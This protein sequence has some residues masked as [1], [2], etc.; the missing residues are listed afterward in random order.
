[1]NP[2]RGTCR[3][4]VPGTP[5]PRLFPSSPP[6]GVC[7][8]PPTFTRAFSRTRSRALPIVGVARISSLPPAQQRRRWPPHRPLGRCP[9]PAPPCSGAPARSRCRTS[10]AR[11]GG[12]LR[13]RPPA[14][15]TRCTSGPGRLRRRQG[16][17]GRLGQHRGRLRH[18]RA[19]RRGA[20]RR[21]SAS[22][23]ADP[24]TIL[25]R[26]RAATT[27]CGWSRTPRSASASPARAKL[28]TTTRPNPAPSTARPPAPR[29]TVRRRPRVLRRRAQRR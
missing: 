12:E 16:R 10:P 22:S 11:P 14:T 2:M 24:E 26:R 13:A 29:T 6:S 1:M 20:G 19:G 23:S 3:R 9:T 5:A 18:L 25:L 21:P 28:V 7:M 15:T 27:P 4:R 8:L 17:Q